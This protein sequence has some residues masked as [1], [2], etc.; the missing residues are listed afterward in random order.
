MAELFHS[1]A[2]YTAFK[3]FVSIFGFEDYV[4]LEHEK[5]EFVIKN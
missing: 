2:L 3:E 4:L 5:S 1:I